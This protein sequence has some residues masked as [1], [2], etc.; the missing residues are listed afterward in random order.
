[1][2]SFCNACA[3]EHGDP[4]GDFTEME[5]YSV[6]LCEGCGAIQ[7][8]EQGNCISSDCLKKHGTEPMLSGL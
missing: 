1:M 2:A 4:R 6:V 7:V 8:D 3:A 5:E